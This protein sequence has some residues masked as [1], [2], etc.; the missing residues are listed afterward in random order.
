MGFVQSKIDEYLF[1]CGKIMCV[2]Y[3]DDSILAGPDKDEID[4]AIKDIKRFGL[5]IMTKGD[6]KDSL[7]F[8]TDEKK[9]GTI[10]LSQPHLIDQ[11]HS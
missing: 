11:I 3:T 10:H 5:N 2:H 8:N 7:G 6:L 4:K 1:Y 9:D